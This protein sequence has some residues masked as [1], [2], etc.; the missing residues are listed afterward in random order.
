MLCEVYLERTKSIQSHNK[1]Y[2]NV[3]ST[4]NRCYKQSASPL[5]C[6]SIADT[7]QAKKILCHIP[8]ATNQMKP[9]EQNFGNSVKN[10]FFRILHVMLPCV[11]CK[12][13]LCNN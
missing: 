6:G 10:Y 8:I 13:L 3:L 5:S 4:S 9:N 2:H 11:K 12:Q 7:V 1:T